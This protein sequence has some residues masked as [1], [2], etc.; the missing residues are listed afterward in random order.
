MSI[1]VVDKGTR[2]NIELVHVDFY[3]RTTVD[4]DWEKAA[5]LGA[6]GAD[7]V[8]GQFKFTPT[9]NSLLSTER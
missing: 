7:F 1:G 6:P 2:E 9:L 8:S 3:A 5:T 4:T